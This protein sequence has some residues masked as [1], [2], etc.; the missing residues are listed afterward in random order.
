LDIA[1]DNT[2][3]KESNQHLMGGGGGMT[4][5]WKP[6]RN[7]FVTFCCFILLLLLVGCCW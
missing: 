7:C 2:A 4:E 5:Y 3:T 1:V 6:C